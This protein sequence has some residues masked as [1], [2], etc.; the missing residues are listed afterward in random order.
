[1]KMGVVAKVAMQAEAATEAVASGMARPVVAVKEVAWK[2]EEGP[3]VATR[4]VEG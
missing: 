4:V 1:M 3:E 2:V